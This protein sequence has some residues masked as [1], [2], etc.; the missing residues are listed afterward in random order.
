MTSSLDRYLR[1]D[2]AP[3]LVSANELIG[4]GQAEHQA[5]L[6]QPEDEAAG[7][8]PLHSSEGA[9]LQI[10]KRTINEA[11]GG[12]AIVPGGLM[13]SSSFTIGSILIAPSCAP[14]R[15]PPSR[16]TAS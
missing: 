2:T 3:P 16:T 15:P 14:S 13:G 6:L 8:D 1:S 10:I 4:E 9:L 5:S 11:A 7:E 12:G